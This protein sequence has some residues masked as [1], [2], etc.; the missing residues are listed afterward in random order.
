M[1][2]GKRSNASRVESIRPG[3]S[4]K[5]AVISVVIPA[6]RAT[7]ISRG[8]SR[9]T[10]ESIAAGV[11]IRPCDGIGHV[12][13][14]I[15]RS[16]PAVMSGLP[17]RPI[18]TIRPSLIPMSA[19]TIPSSGSTTIALGITAS[20]SDGRPARSCCVIRERQFLAYP[21]R[22]WS[23]GSVR[24]S[25]ILIHRSVSPRRTRSPAVGPWRRACCSRE[26]RSGTRPSVRDQRDLFGLAGSPAERVAGGQIEPEALRGV[27]VEGQV[28]V[29]LPEREVR[30]DADRSLAG[31]G[32]GDDPTLAA[33]NER[34]IAFPEADRARLVVTRDPERIPEH[35]QTGSF[36]EQ[37]LDPD[38]RHDT[39]DAADDLIGPQ[40]A[41]P[42]I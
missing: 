28:G 26:M 18:P 32:H 9:W 22:A 39:R 17:A 35:D 21:Q 2:T 31:V 23:P 38:L 40:S 15:V 11:A 7:G 19:F 34:N 42:H 27:A 13:G 8:E 29:R 16:T 37:D 24:S 41:P 5:P 6:D 14:P 4:S 30:G 20:S 36:V 10:C 25:S 33:G 3:G 1:L 12:F